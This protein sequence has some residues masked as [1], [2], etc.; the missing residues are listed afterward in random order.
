MSKAFDLNNPKQYLID[1]G[2]NAALEVA[3][4]LGMPL[5]ITGEPGT[6]KTQLAHHVAREM[7][8]VLQEFYT[9]TTSKARDLFYK[10][11][12]L[13][14]FRD[15]QH[16]GAGVNS[17]SYISFECLGQAILDSPSKRS[18]VLIDEIDKA[19]RDFPNDVLFEFAQ[20]GF[21]V[22]ESGAKE[23]A[24]WAKEQQFALL[25][26]EQGYFRF[27]PAS[28]QR[29]I[30]ILT[31]N[32]EKN[33]PDAFMRRC[34]Y[35]HIPFP[36]RERLAE[37]V[38]QNLDIS[39]DFQNRML[40]HAVGY[41]LSIRRDHG[42]RKKPATAELLAWIHILHQKQFDLSQE[43]NEIEARQAIENE[44][45]NTLSVLTK[46]REDRERIL[47]SLQR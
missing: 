44:L 5:L 7:D 33:L 39:P 15:S 17:M 18:V 26:D 34:V 46:N 10:Y 6:G 32:S 14:H 42:L 30:L 1:P 45:E 25:P 19:P 38:S 11:N 24:E 20:L 23:A 31:S 29:P 16:K 41:F 40:D 2:L 22:Q 3:L 21:K 12:A 28:G 13:T 35:Y 9:K 43:F 47:E 27:D 8:C 37:I 36:S 4:D